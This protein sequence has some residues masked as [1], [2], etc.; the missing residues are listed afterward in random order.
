M[1]IC[2]IIHQLLADHYAIL[3]FELCTVKRD[4]FTFSKR[5]WLWNWITSTQRRLQLL[6]SKREEGYSFYKASQ[7]EPELFIVY[8]KTNQIE[9]IGVLKQSCIKL[10]SLIFSLVA[11][12]CNVDL[13]FEQNILSHI[14]KS[15][16][17]F[18]V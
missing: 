5:R 8:D 15:S 9:D 16:F 14:F 2:K 1:I 6:H 12:R 18:C 17:L 3:H 13:S 10:L 4:D 11:V 7:L